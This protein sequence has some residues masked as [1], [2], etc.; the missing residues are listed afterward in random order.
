MKYIALLR[1][2]NVGG[3]NKVPMLK[4]KAV[5]EVEGY[6]DVC[7]YINSGNVIFSSSEADPIKLQNEIENCLVKAFGLAIKVLVLS[8]EKLDVIAAE[9]PSNWRNDGDMKC[10]VF[11]LWADYNSPKF[12]ADLTIVPGIDTVKYVDGALLW[13]VPRDQLAK[14]GILKIVGGKLYKNVTIRNCN[15]VRKLAELSN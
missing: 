4:L 1:G 7:T 9:L 12:I 3:N 14:S 11:F 2:I 8:K 10:D 6:S 13:S 15:T 5:F